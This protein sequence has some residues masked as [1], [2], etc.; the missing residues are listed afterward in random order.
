M[1]GCDAPATV[2]EL[3]MR[4]DIAGSLRTHDSRFS[5]QLEYP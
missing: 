5:Y 4:Q 3:A 2:E 1:E